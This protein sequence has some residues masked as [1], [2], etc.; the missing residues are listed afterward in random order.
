MAAINYAGLNHD[1]Y[2]VYKTGKISKQVLGVN[3]LD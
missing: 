1:L 3:D 2:F